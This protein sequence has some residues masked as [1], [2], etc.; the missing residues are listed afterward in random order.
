[1]P[2]A[3]IVS[4]VPSL[5]ELVCEL[6]LTDQL[7]GRTGF[8]VHPKPVLDR[9]PKVGGT[10]TVN[11]ARIRSLAPT[12]LIV[13]ID[14]NR[15]DTVEALAEFIPHV[16][17]THPIELDDNLALYRQFGELFDVRSR[18]TELCDAFTAARE[19]AQATNRTPVPVLY[20]IWRKPWMT[21]S[22]PTFIS[23]MLAEV[24]LITWPAQ[25]A[26]R[27]PS[28]EARE[29]AAAPV[30]AVLLP[31]E[32]YRF[33]AA[34]GAA[35]HRLYRNRVTQAGQPILVGIDGEMTSW[36]G[37]RAIAGL[38]Y[39]ARLRPRLERRLARRRA[40]LEVA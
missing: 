22:P 11:L 18:A 24:G 5:T 20:L 6:G 9:V 30:D 36:Y 3:R 23:R 10:K 7:V 15:R 37:P 21:V 29:L 39:L 16:V 12:H 27:Y 38:D 28:L 32:P 33:G 19:R 35:L 40:T 17:V 8:C 13:N 34:D 14:E 1:M 25:S 26:L 2:G 31:T 4:L